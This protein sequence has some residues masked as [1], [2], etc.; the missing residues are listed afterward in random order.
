MPWTDPS[1]DLPA[2]LEQ[3]GERAP[4]VVLFV[5]MEDL[6]ERMARIT[7]AM[8]PLHVVAVARP[9]LLDRVVHALNPVNRNETIIVMRKDPVG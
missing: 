6:A 4:D 7:R 9:G 1:A 5:G 2:E 3:H 8:G